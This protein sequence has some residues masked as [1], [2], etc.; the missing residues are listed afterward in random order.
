[1]PGGIDEA[2][3]G[4]KNTDLRDRLVTLTL[5]LEATDRSG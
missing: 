2:S 1:L 5:Q 3:V 4:S